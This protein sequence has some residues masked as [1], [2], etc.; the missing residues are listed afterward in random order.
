VIENQ[1][2]LTA[3]EQ[4]RTE[5]SGA[6]PQSAGM[7]REHAEAVLA[8]V[9]AD[10]KLPQLNEK[11]EIIATRA[12]AEEIAMRVWWRTKLFS[13]VG[14]NQLFPGLKNRRAKQ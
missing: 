9:A 11:R 10:K 2:Q 13:P 14:L 3:G 4:H 12:E 5:T 7:S 6:T 1:T 8:V